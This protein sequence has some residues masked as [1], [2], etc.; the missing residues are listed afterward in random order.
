VLLIVAGLMI[1]SF[2][3]IQ[4]T[5]FGFDP[6]N[7][8]T[9]WVSLTRQR[10]DNGTKVR[11]FY[12]QLL[13]N[14]STLPGVKHAAVSSSLPLVSDA[15]QSFDIQGMK[16][17][18]APHAFFTVVSPQYF[19]ALGIPFLS[20]REFTESDVATA[21]PVC[22]I[23]DKLVRAYFRD[24]NPIG[25]YI[26]DG[27]GPNNTPHWRQIVGVVGGVKHVSAVAEETKGEVYIPFQQM[28]MRTL[29]VIL[30]TD[31]DPQPLISALRRAVAQLDPN[32][33]VYDV[34]PMDQYVDNFIAQPRFNTVLLGLFGGLA[35]VL[36]AVGVYGVI[37]Y[38]VTQR[39]HE[40][41]VRMALGAARGD[42]LQLVLRESLRLA[43]AGIGIGLVAALAATRALSGLLFG[44]SVRDPLTFTALAALLIAVAVLASYVPA[45]RAAK[46]DPM[47]ALRYE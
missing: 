24:Q 31:G 46:V 4:Q 2:V 16:L 3:R 28:P 12:Q 17:E 22:L 23:D 43:A 8:L 27:T 25:K 40:I 11:S 5:R 14:V 26:D 45:R 19:S 13:Q 6:N 42:V 35:L 32:Q 41:G 21:P 15:T 30:R 44:T 34:L 29:S 9:A 1:R 20:G 39:T 37:S 33:A 10:Y 38:W 7:T 18:P 47:V 36:A